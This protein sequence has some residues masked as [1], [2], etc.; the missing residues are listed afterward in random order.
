MTCCGLEE[1]ENDFQ[2]L[3]PAVV[4][5]AS[6]KCV[7]QAG[8]LE[9]QVRV[10]IGVISLEATRQQAGNLGWVSALLSCHQVAAGQLGEWFISG[11]SVGLH[12]TQQ[13]L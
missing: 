7:W 13:W 6:L 11:L 12:C 10:D 9:T 8:R 1:R 4:R 5:L 3:T 2:G